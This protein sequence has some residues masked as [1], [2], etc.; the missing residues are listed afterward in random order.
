MKD[1]DPYHVV[2]QN[3]L[4][5]KEADTLISWL[6]KLNPK[7]STMQTDE[8]DEKAGVMKQAHNQA[9]TSENA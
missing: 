4:S 9:R 8:L 7:R 3:L 5:D 1:G 6:E 2:F